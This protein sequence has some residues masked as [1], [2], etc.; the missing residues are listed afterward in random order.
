MPTSYMFDAFQSNPRDG[1]KDYIQDNTLSSGS[2]AAQ[3]ENIAAE[4]RPAD[5]T[6]EPVN[7]RSPA[8]SSASPSE[9]HYLTTLASP[10][11]SSRHLGGFNYH[12]CHI[13]AKEAS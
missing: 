3:H 6:E 13:Y 8:L 9:G 1:G 5:P 7:P 11:I 4:S 12:L 10:S 2:P